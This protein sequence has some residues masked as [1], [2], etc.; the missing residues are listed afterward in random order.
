MPI[1]RCPELTEIRKYRRYIAAAV[2]SST[3]LRAG[4]LRHGEEAC[5]PGLMF[6]V[7]RVFEVL[8]VN[9]RTLGL[10]CSS[11]LRYRNHCAE[12]AA[13]IVKIVTITTH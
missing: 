9:D 13:D 11:V 10:R 6:H 5:S 8:K 7:S 4:N 2:V 1:S 12:L 3:E